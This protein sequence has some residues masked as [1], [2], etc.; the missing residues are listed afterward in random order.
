[1]KWQCNWRS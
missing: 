1:M